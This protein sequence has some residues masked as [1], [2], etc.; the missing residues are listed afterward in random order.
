VVKHTNFHRTVPLLLKLFTRSRAM[1]V[2]QSHWDVEH[3]YI[4]ELHVKLQVVSVH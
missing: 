1:C 2:A 3:I 4:L